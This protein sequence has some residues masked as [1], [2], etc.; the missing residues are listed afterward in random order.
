[1]KMQLINFQ[2][3]GDDRGSLIV[4]EN[5]KEVPFE[6]KRIY[7]LFDTKTGVRRGF[8]AH[9]ELQQLA[10]CVN[11]S[12]EFLMDD[13]YNVETIKLDNNNTGLILPPMVWHEMFN[14]SPNCIL[15]ILAD[16]LYD[17]S[18]Y[19]RSYQEFTKEIKYFKETSYEAK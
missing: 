16:R 12:C 18:D 8:H 9:R 11:G 10:I 7:Y 3:K 1:M 6:I 19:I 4:L 5:S 15:M 2:Q 14:F 17:E 13:G